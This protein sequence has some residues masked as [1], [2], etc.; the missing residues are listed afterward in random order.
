MM[1][2]CKTTLALKH[3]DYSSLL[4]LSTVLTHAIGKTAIVLLASGFNPKACQALNSSSY[5]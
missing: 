4:I 3:W 2:D 1:H 5:E